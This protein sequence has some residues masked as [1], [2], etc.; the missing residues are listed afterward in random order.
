MNPPL[1]LVIDQGG[2]STRALVLDHQGVI[3]AQSRVRVDTQYPEPGHVEQNANEVACSIDAAL[4]GICAKLA[5]QV[6]AIDRAGLVT[7]RSSVLCWDKRTGTPLSP[8]LSWQ[9][10]R[11]A[12]S[13]TQLNISRDRI[14]EKTGLRVNAHYGAN[15]IKWCLNHLSAVRDAADSGHLACGPLA[16]FLLF[17]LTDETTFAVDEANA[18]RTLLF[19][20]NTGQWDK[21]LLNI[22]QIPCTIL[23]EP[24]PTLSEFGTLTLGDHAIP[25]RL[26][27]GDQCA[28]FF[29]NGPLRSDRIIVNAGTGAFIAAPC[30]ESTKIPTE[31]LKTLVCSSPG[32]RQF[33]IEGT[34]NG[35]ASALDWARDTLALTDISE[36]D[37]WC[38]TT[39]YPPLFMNGVGGLGSPYW[40]PK[41]PS[42]FVL[43]SDSPCEPQAKLVAVLESIVFL[44]MVNLMCLRQTRKA[45]AFTEIHL[46]GGLSRI[47]SLGQ[48]LAD[49]SGLPVY[50]DEQSETTACGAAYLLMGSPE[51]WSHE[52]AYFRPQT[53]E[54]LTQ[55]FQQWR[56]KIEH[57]ISLSRE[58]EL[59]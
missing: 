50:R 37:A 26:V 22:F 19:N 4:N 38:N 8:V 28:A 13:L 52:Y 55:R 44:L 16:S 14:S 12:E 46:G 41:F 43:T 42:K 58:T 47:D 48:K 56:T 20:I 36:L 1:A 33:V 29:S 3:V 53:N 23:P 39:P 24:T 9:D 32:Q 30:S 40:C 49:L 45:D 15:K 11:A 25:I 6:T 57:R 2:H 21:E 34:V 54:T 35:A 31:L 17:R 27:N 18:S 5:D 7:Q 10:T 59:T 51:H